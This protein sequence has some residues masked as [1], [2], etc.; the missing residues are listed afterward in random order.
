[1]V[2]GQPPFARTLLAARW[3]DFA[4]GLGRLLYLLKSG[5]VARRTF[6]FCKNLFWFRS[7]HEI[8]FV[9]T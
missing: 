5:A 2:A 7:F 3:I 1:M 8:Y 4:T 9:G 6:D